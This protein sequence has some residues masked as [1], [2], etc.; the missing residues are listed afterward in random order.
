MSHLPTGPW[1]LSQRQPLQPWLETAM[2][3]SVYFNS[4]AMVV[5]SWPAQLHSVKLLSNEVQLFELQSLNTFNC[6]RILKQCLPDTS[7]KHFSQHY[8]HQVSDVVFSS[9]DVSK[10]H[11]RWISPGCTFNPRTYVFF[12]FQLSLLQESQWRKVTGGGSN[13]TVTQIPL[14]LPQP[15]DRQG[16]TV[17]SVAETWDL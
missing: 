12:C 16:W 2:P 11:I 15:E 13:Y 4:S 3:L 5:D 9:L 14:F 10:C 17:A 8:A 7:S 6:S 1:W